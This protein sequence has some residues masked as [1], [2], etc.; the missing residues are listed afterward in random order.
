[1]GGASLPLPSLHVMLVVLGYAAASALA[2]GAALGAGLASGFTTARG[3]TVSSSCLVKVRW[4]ARMLAANSNRLSTITD[5]SGSWAGYDTGSSGTYGATVSATLLAT[6]ST[7][8]W[9]CLMPSR[10]WSSTL[11]RVS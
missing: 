4:A 3:A 2:L 9:V 8:S 7:V 1:M 5:G 6:P 11:V 10:A